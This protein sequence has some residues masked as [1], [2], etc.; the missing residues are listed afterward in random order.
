MVM[1]EKP[2]KRPRVPPN[3][4]TFGS[5]Y[6]HWSFWKWDETDQ[7]GEG[8]DQLLRLNRDV[9]RGVPKD[10]AKT[11]V[12]GTLKKKAWKYVHFL[13]SLVLPKDSQRIWIRCSCTA[14]GIQSSLLL[15]RVPRN[16]ATHILWK[17]PWKGAKFTYIKNIDCTWTVWDFDRCGCFLWSC[18]KEV[19]TQLTW[20]CSPWYSWEAG[21]KQIVFCILCNEYVQ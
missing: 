5:K 14:F 6:L 15:G 11:L 2:R 16:W 18:P 1:K 4:A 8:V 13:H 3:S 7:W 10:Q 9:G 17:R 19:Y 21:I 20:K 12:R